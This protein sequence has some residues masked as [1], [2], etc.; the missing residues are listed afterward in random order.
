MQSD[1]KRDWSFA[2]KT[3]AASHVVM[4]FGSLLYLVAVK[5]SLSYLPFYSLSYADIHDDSG[6]FSFIAGQ[7]YI[8]QDTAF[9]PLYPALIAAIHTIFRVSIP[10]AGLFLSNVFM[11]L[12]IFVLV[13]LFRTKLD[14]RTAKLGAVLFAIFPMANFLASM[15][16]ESLFIFTFC[17]SLW[18]LARDKYFLAAV[19]GACAVLTRNEGVLVL[20]P[21]VIRVWR[22]YKATGHVKKKA[23][24]SM[25]MIPGALMGYCAFLWIRFGDP[26]LFSHVEKL[27]GREFMF[28]LETIYLGFARFDWLWQ[29]NGFYGHM[30]YTIENLSVIFAIC[31]VP[32]IW[33]F[34]S[35]EWAIITAL[36]ILIPLS[37][38]GVGINSIVSAPHR[39]VDYFF[40]FPRFVLPMFGVYA[41]LAV[42]LR[43]AWQKYLAVGVSSLGLAASMFAFSSHWFMS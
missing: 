12:S 16:T 25:L 37:D 35:K 26:L 20:M 24:L 21:F 17:A 5:H 43:K 14:E 1:V 38:P 4:L 40:S 32:V 39:I 33:R 36:M 31:L 7:G 27:W 42:L 15:Y 18:L 10:T 6:W 8:S 23:A 3:W 30:Y 22:N 11:I 9:F 13:Q 19:F 2:V 28:P 29:H 41:G 34:V